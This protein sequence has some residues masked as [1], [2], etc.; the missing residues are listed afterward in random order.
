MIGI[1]ARNFHSFGFS[2]D[3]GASSIE[4]TIDRDITITSISTAIYDSNLETPTNISKFSSI[5]YLH[6]KNNYIKSLPDQ[7][8]QQVLQQQVQREMKNPMM[9]YQPAMAQYRTQPPVQV[10]ADYYKAHWNGSLNTIEENSDE[11]LE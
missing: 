3:L 9:Y 11:D 2:F 7:V 6:T 1:N 10:P 5:I 8:V 4:Y